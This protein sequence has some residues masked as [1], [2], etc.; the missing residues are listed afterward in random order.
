[1]GA[2]LGSYG[3]LVS[4]AM[5]VPFRS[6][7]FDSLW[8]SAS[9]RVPR[10]RQKLMIV[11]H[12][13]GDSRDSFADIR[14]ELRLPEMNYLL[15]NAPKKS[16]DGFSWYSLEPRHAKDVRRARLG[17][18]ALIQE[19]RRE[20]WAQEDIFFLGHSQ[21]ALMVC[22]LLMTHPGTFGGAVGISGYVWFFR[23]WKTIARTSA[24]WTTPWLMTYGTRDRVIPPAEI[25]ED[26]EKLWSA[27]A[28]VVAR[29]FV[30]GHDFDYRH[31]VPFVREWLKFQY[32]S[33]RQRAKNHS[34][35]RRSPLMFGGDLSALPSHRRRTVRP[36]I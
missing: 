36:R 30:K 13:L 25:R 14:Q 7:Q 24:A 11:L 3:K 12:G 2:G 28:P 4:N 6:R 1:M 19:L 10:D 34:H 17:L 15:L 16:G 32:A 31:E 9:P 33:S 29:A 20:G 5:A 35:S 22:D 21:G 26:L 23:G 27:G 18:F 8:I